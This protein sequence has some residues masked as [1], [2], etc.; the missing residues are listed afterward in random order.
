MSRSQRQLHG[1]F[2]RGGRIQRD[3]RLFHR[4]SGCGILRWNGRDRAHSVSR[5]FLP[6]SSICAL[7]SVSGNIEPHA[8]LYVAAGS[9]RPRKPRHFRYG[10][11]GNGAA[12]VN[13]LED[14]APAGHQSCRQRGRR[15]PDHRPEYVGRDPGIES[16]AARRFAHLARI[17]LRQ[18]TPCRPNWTMSAP[19]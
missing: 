8:R 11:P 12:R 7:E 17:G 18:A 6:G 15:Q 5:S 16:R 2:G 19:R 13:L 9:V 14:R 3:D 10:E 1:P 4:H